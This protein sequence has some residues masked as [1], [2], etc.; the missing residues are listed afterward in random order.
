LT[1]ATSYKRNERPNQDELSFYETNTKYN[2]LKPLFSDYKSDHT[3]NYARSRRTNN[4]T[5]QSTARGNISMTTSARI[6]RKNSL[7]NFVNADD[8]DFPK[9]SDSDDDC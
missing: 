8:F 1:S 2:Y 4:P 7:N 6:Q 5:R 3:I 9:E